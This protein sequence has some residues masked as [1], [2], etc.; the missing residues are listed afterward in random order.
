[1]PARFPV[2]FPGFFLVQISKEF[3]MATSKTEHESGPGRHKAGRSIEDRGA[4]KHTHGSK[5]SR[6]RDQGSYWKID[7]LERMPYREAP[8]RSTPAESESSSTSESDERDARR[9]GRPESADDDDTIITRS[10]RLGGADEAPFAD[11]D[12]APDAVER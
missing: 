3:L 9:G 1:M 7:P 4:G 10:D 11:D 12:E 5:H 6:D 2:L 8:P